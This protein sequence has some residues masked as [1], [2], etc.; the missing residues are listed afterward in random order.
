MCSRWL[1]HVDNTTTQPTRLLSR[2]ELTSILTPSCRAHLECFEDCTRRCPWLDRWI[3]NTG[4]HRRRASR[5]N[6]YLFRSPITIMFCACESLIHRLARCTRPTIREEPLSLLS[7][8][9]FRV[10]SNP[11]AG[12]TSDFTFATCGIGRNEIREISLLLCLLTFA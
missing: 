3:V 11:S 10:E 7:L 9:H 1:C 5:S 12:H 6:I 2:D 4:R 8:A